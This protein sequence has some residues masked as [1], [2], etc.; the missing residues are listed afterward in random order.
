MTSKA[1]KFKQV[2]VY[3]EFDSEL[4]ALTGTS[5]EKIII[6]EGIPVTMFLEAVFDTYSSIFSG[7]S[8]GDLGLSINGK[9]PGIGDQLSENDTIRLLIAG[10]ESAIW[11]FYQP[12]IEQ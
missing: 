7:F 2:T 10:D 9:A 6:S 5:R 4:E 11:E 8:W 12:Q 1:D 3:L